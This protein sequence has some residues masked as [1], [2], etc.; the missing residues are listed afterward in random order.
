MQH[1]TQWQAHLSL[2]E[3]ETTTLS[4]LAAEHLASDRF[5]VITE[6]LEDGSDGPVV[7]SLDVDAESLGG[8]I[9]AAGSAWDSLRAAGGLKPAPLILQFVVGPL[10]RPAVFHQTLMIR[11]RGLLASDQPAY[12]VV[13][14]QTAFEVYIGGLLGDLTRGK[15]SPELAEAI[16]PRLRSLRDKASSQLFAAVVGRKV[17]EAGP[18]WQAYETHVQRRNGVVH[19]GADIDE[20]AAASSL[21]A[22]SQLIEWIDAT[23]IRTG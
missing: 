1:V 19:D 22:V 6:I 16:Q 2:R 8:A 12:A 13:A 14:A 7:L 15:M 23:V 21:S 9:N 4:E 17:T 10:D 5:G 18:L 3:G 20:D 11:A